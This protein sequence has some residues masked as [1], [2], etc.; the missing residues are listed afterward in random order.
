[1]SGRAQLW[2]AFVT[3]L[4]LAVVAIVLESRFGPAAGIPLLAALFVF[5]HFVLRPARRRAEAQLPEHRRTPPR[6]ARALP[7]GLVAA[8]VVVFVV[9][10]ATS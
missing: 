3:G 2:L 10:K 6:W 1:M 7:W 9:T 4:L 5:G 8:L